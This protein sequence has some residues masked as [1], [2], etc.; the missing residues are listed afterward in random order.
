M[1]EP[2]ESGRSAE[3]TGGMASVTRVFITLEGGSVR[4]EWRGVEPLTALGM[5]EIAKQAILRKL[6]P[7]RADVSGVNPDGRLADSS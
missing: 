3:V 5:L 1:A 6:E 7:W 2:E 4:T